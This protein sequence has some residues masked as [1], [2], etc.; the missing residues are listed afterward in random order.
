[1]FKTYLYI[2]HQLEERITQTAK[3]QK[4]SKAEVM[5]EALEKGIRV[6][7]H[8]GSA[9]LEVLF[10]LEEMGKRNKVRGPKDAAER[11]DEYLYG[12]DWSTNE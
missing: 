4:K 12:K 5:R 10:K 6:V 7:R 8:Q 1:M 11:F 9:S 3:V 2:P